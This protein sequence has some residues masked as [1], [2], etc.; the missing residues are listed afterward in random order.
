MKF[1]GSF[2]ARVGV[3]VALLSSV[4]SAS[5]FDDVSIFPG[6]ELTMGKI[7]ASDR[8]ASSAVAENYSECLGC[9]G[10]QEPI[11]F[12]TPTYVEPFF[13]APVVYDDFATFTTFD[14]FGYS[15]VY[16]AWVSGSRVRPV[17]NFFRR[18]RPVRRVLSR[19][20]NAV[21]RDFDYCR[22][23]YVCDPCW[24]CA[25][26][27]DPCAITT[28][29]C[30]PCAFTPVPVSVFAPRPCCGYGYYPGEVN[31]LDPNTGLAKNVKRNP[32]IA[33]AADTNSSSKS[34]PAV[35]ST[36]DSD[37]AN[38]N[39]N[40]NTTD[41]ADPLSSTPYDQYDS[42][43]GINAASD[44]TGT[45]LNQEPTLD[46]QTPSSDKKFEYVPTPPSN[47]ELKGSGLIRMLVPENAV[48][49]VNGYRTKQKGR[50]RSFA[51]RE[52]EKGQSYTF[53][54][55]VVALC[56]GKLREEVKSTTLVAGDSAA[57]A[58]D[59]RNEDV[60]ALNR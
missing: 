50:V 7:S 6:Q 10:A 34:A 1:S 20:Y 2:A 41:D 48:V 12:A 29:V 8:F 25:D 59:F 42:V 39:T 43:Q 14:G 24:S 53:E 37:A 60:Y 47:E 55:R 17:K 31:E 4:V 51:A 44:A 40:T 9:A 38:T 23:A 57:L 52:L 22:P 56:D 15:Y 19:V 54:I 58:F 18:A 36:D 5:A 35:V 21:R 13:T 28:T 11:S 26:V 45:D 49:Y 3:V 30:D 32:G 33:A 16:D 46:S 27:C